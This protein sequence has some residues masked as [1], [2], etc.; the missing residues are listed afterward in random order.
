MYKC[1]SSIR[2]RVQSLRIHTEQK[3]LRNE[4]ERLLKDT[5]MFSLSLL[6]VLLQFYFIKGSNSLATVRSGLWLNA[7]FVNEDD[8]FDFIC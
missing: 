6:H 5:N 2:Y 3:A 4:E 7:E 8:P 1:S